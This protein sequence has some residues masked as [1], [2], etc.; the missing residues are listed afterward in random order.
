MYELTI[1]FIGGTVFKTLFNGEEEIE[2]FKNMIEKKE[3][4]DN[5]YFLRTQTN[6]GFNVANINCYQIKKIEK[7]VKS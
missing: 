2:H 7:E 5:N 1:Y 4:K 3:I 6:E